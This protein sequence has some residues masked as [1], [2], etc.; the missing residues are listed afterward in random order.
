MGE[1]SLPAG[2]A[3][4]RPGQ[5]L[6]GGHISGF[7]AVETA[8]QPLWPAFDHAVESTGDFSTLTEGQR[9]VAFAWVL[10][11][12]VDNGGFASW[13]ESFGDRTPQA[14]AAM[15]HLG[16]V[17]YVALL[18]E[19]VRLYPHWAAGTPAERSSAA[20]GWTDAEEARRDALDEAFYRLAAERNLVEHYAAGYVAAH[21]EEFPTA[22]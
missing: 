11:G 10:S 15:E 13:I 21:P 7:D 4:G 8:L 9:A 14:R 17:E 18:D 6:K 5:E 22:S 1:V 12:L 20:E 19:A 2:L 16:A 3:L